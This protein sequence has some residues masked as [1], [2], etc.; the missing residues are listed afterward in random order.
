MYEDLKVMYIK[1]F[2]KGQGCPSGQIQILWNNQKSW[3]LTCTKFEASV[4]GSCST[5]I[6]NNMSRPCFSQKTSLNA[7]HSRVWMTYYRSVNKVLPI[8]SW[9]NVK[10]LSCISRSCDC[11]PNMY[12]RSTFKNTSCLTDNEYSKHLVTPTWVG[13][14]DRDH[15]MVVTNWT[16]SIAGWGK[17]K[18][19]EICYLIPIHMCYKTHLPPSLQL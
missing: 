1:Q 8:E 6:A 3:G 15:C 17:T 14:Y 12:C 16:K 2:P 7:S 4:M 11:S 9:Y 10:N 18:D 19:K 5:R 13:Q